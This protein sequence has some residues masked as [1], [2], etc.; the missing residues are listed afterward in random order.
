MSPHAI[1]DR[2]NIWHAEQH[3]SGDWERPFVLLRDRHAAPPPVIPSRLDSRRVT[4][5][6]RSQFLDPYLDPV[7]R[8]SRARFFVKSMSIWLGRP[9]LPVMALCDGSGKSA[10]TLKQ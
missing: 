5:L 4:I 6:F 2:G 1:E 10:L 9:T 3:G 7:S 8:E